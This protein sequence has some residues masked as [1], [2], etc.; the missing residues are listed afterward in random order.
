[1]TTL[2][3]RRIALSGAALLLIKNWANAARDCAR[4]S[5]YH[6]S[7]RAARD[8]MAGVNRVRV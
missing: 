5:G 7:H 1:M 4:R 6:A 8:L 2:T 3:A